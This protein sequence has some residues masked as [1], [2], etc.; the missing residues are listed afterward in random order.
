M[1]AT[2][3][4]QMDPLLSIP[5]CSMKNLGGCLALLPA[6]GPP[7]SSPGTAPGSLAGKPR[8]PTLGGMVSSEQRGLWSGCCSHWSTET[9]PAAPLGGWRLKTGPVPVPHRPHLLSRLQVGGKRRDPGP[10][11]L[12]DNPKAF[13]SFRALDWT[14]TLCSHDCWVSGPKEAVSLPRALPGSREF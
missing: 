10:S 3:Q 4:S 1:A 13:P 6:R 7:P 9:G 5:R 8:P 2:H 12:S 11:V 14:P